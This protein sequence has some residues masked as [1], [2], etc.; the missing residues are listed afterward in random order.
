MESVTGIGCMSEGGWKS[1][2]GRWRNGGGTAEERGRKEGRLKV[3]SSRMT[4]L[5]GLENEGNERVQG[6]GLQGEVGGVE[7]GLKGREWTEKQY[8]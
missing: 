7:R 4:N 8:G 3:G 6:E 2:G 1:G 5:Y